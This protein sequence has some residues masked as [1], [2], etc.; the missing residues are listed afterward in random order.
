MK[1]RIY[2]STIITIFSII[3]IAL[4][5]SC[6]NN[7]TDAENN[8]SP[9]PLFDEDINTVFNGGECP[10]EDPDCDPN[11]GNVGGTIVIT[12]SYETNFNPQPQWSLQ[13]HPD[14]P[15]NETYIKVESTQTNVQHSYTAN[16]VGN[17]SGITYSW[18]AYRANGSIAA[19][20]SS[21]TFQFISTSVSPSN[22]PGEKV[23]L[24]IFDPN[25]EYHYTCWSNFSVQLIS[26]SEE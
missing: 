24:V 13:P 5:Y 16:F 6:A 1:F 23:E 12:A 3:A 4:M 21:Q 10:D 18:T 8:N 26:N 22:P 17:P 9:S 11:G 14:D 2:R 19:T 15:E 25:T 7:I 20:G